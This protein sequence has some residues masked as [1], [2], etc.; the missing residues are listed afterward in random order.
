MQR[1]LLIAVAAATTWG[2]TDATSAA[3]CSYIATYPSA[4]G[5]HTFL[6]ATATPA[7]VTTETDSIDL[8][9]RRR[10]VPGQVMR[11]RD[12]AGYRT[13]AIRAGL[14]KSGNT[15]VFVRYGISMSCGPM[16]EPDGALDSAGVS[17]LYVASPRSEDRWVDGRPTFDVYRAPHYPLPQR[18]SGP[19]GHFVATYATSKPTMTARELFTMYRALWAESVSVG[20]RS[21]ETRIRNWLARHRSTARKHPAEQVAGAML[22]EG[23]RARLA[24]DRIPFSLRVTLPR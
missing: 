15:A 14:R 1:V 3:R 19:S 12:V 16:A 6:L 8:F 9:R 13:A 18:L 17:G 10:V 2:V 5:K 23:V 11:V 21:P 4:V 22:F 7:V 20:D 24:A